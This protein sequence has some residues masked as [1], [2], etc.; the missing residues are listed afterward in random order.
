MLLLDHRRLLINARSEIALLS[1]CKS[2]AVG[3]LKDPVSTSA[4]KQSVKLALNGFSGRTKLYPRLV[5]GS[6]LPFVGEFHTCSV[7]IGNLAPPRRYCP[8]SWDTFRF[9]ARAEMGWLS[10]FL[11]CSYDD[12][13]VLFFGR[14]AHCR[15]LRSCVSVIVSL[16]GSV[17]AFYLQI[18]C[19]ATPLSKHDLGGT[20]DCQLRHWM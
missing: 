12:A 18:E 10:S 2:A 17:V 16:Y 15:L 8:R 7:R 11:R 13:V 6:S 1:W 4:Y 5:F 9:L 14:G 3:V 19:E 20:E